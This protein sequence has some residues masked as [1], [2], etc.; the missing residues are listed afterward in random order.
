MQRNRN[1]LRFY[2]KCNK[3]I[4]KKYNQLLAI[5]YVEFIGTNFFTN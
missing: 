1:E 4:K 3:N 2:P 5:K